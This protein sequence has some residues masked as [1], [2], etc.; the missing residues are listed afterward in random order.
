MD[1]NVGLGANNNQNLPFQQAKN[2]NQMGG[3]NNSN[4]NSFNQNKIVL[5]DQGKNNQ[6]SKSVN[7]YIKNLKNLFNFPI[8]II[9]H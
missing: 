3:N 4:K 7:F 2:M 6:K 8:R 1:Y 9:T 5:R